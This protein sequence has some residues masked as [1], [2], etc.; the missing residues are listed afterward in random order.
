[1]TPLRAVLVGAGAMG[2]NWA[3]NL[4]AS[5]EVELAGWVDI[6]PGL[7]ARSAQ[8]LGLTGGYTGEDLAD[9]LRVVQPD[10]VVDVSIPEAHHGVTL[11]ALAASLPVLG[12]KPMA[13]T[14]EHAREMVAAA[15][16]AGKLYM[17]SQ[18][19]R[20]QAE[21]QAFRRLIK[22]QLGPLG[23]LNSDF[24]IGAHFGGFRDAMAS[25][26]LLDMAIHTFDAA[27]YLSGSDPVAV[28]CEEF[29]PTWS[30]YTGNACATAIF[31]MSGGL[32]Y[33][34]RGSWCSEG[35]ST[36]WEGEWRAVGPQGTAVWDGTE[37]P[38]AE[39]VT[40]SG[41]F[42]AETETCTTALEQN[43][44]LGIAGSLQDFVQ[45]LRTGATPMGECHDNIKSLAMV[46]GAIESVQTGQ[47]V[48]IL[49]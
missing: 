21:L 22:D 2:R 45:A 38:I 14:M 49:H 34:Y 6:Q 3:K 9:A 5:P 47:R 48:S 15:E 12:E 46:F 25:P 4:D 28:Y 43:L 41:G 39:V 35:R 29:N 40:G 20:Y 19:R 27:R 16:Q 33:T 26:L 24:Y 36:S 18:S 13:D 1:M 42:Q 11:Q 37:P 32:R 8:E 44:A 30:W 17:V 31:E 10:F 7:A 23:I